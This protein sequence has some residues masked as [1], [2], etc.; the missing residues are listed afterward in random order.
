MVNQNQERESTEFKLLHE[1]S[2]KSDRRM[3]AMEA[4]WGITSESSF[5]TAQMD[6]LQRHFD[7]EVI[8]CTGYDEA[9]E[10]FGYPEN[11][12]LDITIKNGSLLICELKSSVDRAALYTFKRKALYYE[13]QQQYTANQLLVISPMISDR[14]RQ[15][16]NKL[17]IECYDDA[18]DVV[19]I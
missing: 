2:E 14:A 12:E 6:V 7:V 3:I 10:V 1:K 5:H 4:H 9:G 16:A 15:A 19:Q 18:L 17:G 13:C 8:N 11:I